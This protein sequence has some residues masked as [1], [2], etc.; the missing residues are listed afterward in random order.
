MSKAPR[1]IQE[2]DT[3]EMLILRSVGQQPLAA[4][5]ITISGVLH[6]RH[7]QQLLTSAS[8]RLKLN[9]WLR[10]IHTPSLRGQYSLVPPRQCLLLACCCSLVGFSLVFQSSLTQFD[11]QIKAT[12]YASLLSLFEP[13]D[14]QKR[15]WP[16]S[17]A[18][19]HLWS[20]PWVSGSTDYWS[21]SNRKAVSGLSIHTYSALHP[22]RTPEHCPFHG[23]E[24]LRHPQMTLKDVMNKIQISYGIVGFFNLALSQS[25]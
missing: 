5:G 17:Q 18:S 7:H 13:F 14:I 24:L 4:S 22:A 1:L 6:W 3:T 23:V 20:A 8:V 19:L 15:N 9:K 25:E 12:I 16:Q 10:E 2:Y 21:Y 11:L